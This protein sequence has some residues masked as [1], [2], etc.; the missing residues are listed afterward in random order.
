MS[1]EEI[2]SKSKKT[3]CNGIELVYFFIL[4]GND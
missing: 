2:I 1:L 3:S 4:L